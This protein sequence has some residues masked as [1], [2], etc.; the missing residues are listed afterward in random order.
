MNEP[1]DINELLKQLSARASEYVDTVFII[2]TKVHDDGTTHSY[3]SRKGNYYA[4]YGAVK[5][6]LD[7]VDE[8][9]RW[10]TRRQKDQ[11]NE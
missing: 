9:S 3:I 8:S 11:E 6:W 7:T 10:E 2:A 4:N 5:D 1:F